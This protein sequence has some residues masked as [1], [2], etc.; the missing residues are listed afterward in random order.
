HVVGVKSEHTID[1]QRVPFDLRAEARDG[2][3]DWYSTRLSGSFFNQVCGNTPETRIKYTGLQAPVA[4]AA[5]RKVLA[6]A[7]A[8]D[9]S[10]TTFSTHKFDLSLLDKAKE[11][12]RTAT[13][14][15]RP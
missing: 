6:A 15:I 7:V 3:A 8:Q 13:P 12:A 4:P 2:L 1:A 14:K 11:L 10:L 5:A 9:E